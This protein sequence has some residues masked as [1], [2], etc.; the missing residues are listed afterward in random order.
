[1]V[2]IPKLQAVAVEPSATKKSAVHFTED[3]KL[4]NVTPGEQ[5]GLLDAVRTALAE[6]PVTSRLGLTVKLD[7]QVV[8]LLGS[9]STYYAKQMAQEVIR[10]ALKSY[11]PYPVL[12]NAIVVVQLK[13]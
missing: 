6:N 12:R 13:G 2:S 9:V 5:S 1:M 4:P 8:V 10:P 11:H 7:G 3:E